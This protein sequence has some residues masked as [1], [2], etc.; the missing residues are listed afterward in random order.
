M[1][2]SLSLLV[3]LLTG[4]FYCELVAKEKLFSA[5]LKNNVMVDIN[6]ITSHDKDMFVCAKELWMNTFDVLYKE[7]TPEQLYLKNTSEALTS[8]LK[9]AFEGEE[10]DFNNDK[11]DVLFVVVSD[12][13]TNEIVAFASYDINET[14]ENKTMYIRQLALN[15]EYRNQGLGKALILDMVKIIA[16]NN[17]VLVTVC[18]RDIN[19]SA[20][21][22]YHKLNFQ[23][24]SIKDIHPGWSE[25]IWRGF[26]LIV[27]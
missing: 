7:Y 13:Q 8:L 15:K 10:D 21:N 26:K 9:I 6:K 17:P 19:E 1:K 4:S 3:L 5:T 2:N 20:I 23:D 27:N 22:F 14:S 25:H 24:A 18:T 16:Q 11:E 12:V